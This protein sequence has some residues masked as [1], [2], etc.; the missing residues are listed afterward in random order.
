M[1]FRNPLYLD[2]SM[3]ENLAEYFGVELTGEAQVTRRT[4]AERKGSAGAKF[5]IDVSGE[6]GSVDEVTEVYTTQT[7]PVRAMND[8]IDELI[9]KDQL[10]DLSHD[11]ES[12]VS[13]R[14]VIQL[15]GDFSVS[16]ATEIGAIMSV[17]MPTLLSQAADGREELDMTDE[18]KGTLLSAFVGERKPSE[19][20]M[21]VFDIDSD[22]PDTKVVL[23]AD[24]AHLF[25]SNSLDDLEGERTVFG[26]VDRLVSDGRSYS[27]ER[28]L[29]PGLNRTLRRHLK[30]QGG[31]SGMV[32]SFKS[33]M[34]SEVDA[35]A[36]EVPGPALIV[37]AVA[38]Y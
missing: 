38:I 5:G 26:T 24:P 18:V 29:L 9:E 23:L 4:M 21:H 13:Q 33:F 1:P 10:V 16:R 11:P 17:L 34:G 28:H 25:G 30:A 6:K 37:T 7:R 2:V 3:L 8:V 36:L 35:S 27:L 31:L 20:V 15:D 19:G 22:V 12:P 32:E 14:D